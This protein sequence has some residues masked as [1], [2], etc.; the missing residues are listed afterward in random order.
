MLLERYY[1]ESLAQASYLIACEESR[2]AIVIDPKVE[3]DFDHAR[4]RV[5]PKYVTESF[6]PMRCC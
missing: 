3:T 4:I 6:I 5:K 2:E 1:D